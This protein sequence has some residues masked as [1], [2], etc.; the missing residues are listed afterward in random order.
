MVAA[1]PVDRPAHRVAQEP[2]LQ[3]LVLYPRVHSQ[4]GIE[5]SFR[6][7]ISDEFERPEEAASA[8]VAHVAMLAERATQLVFEALPRR[9]DLGE[10]ATLAQSLLHCQS[11]GTGGGMSE[12]GGAVLEEP[13][14]A[15]D[16]FVDRPRHDHR[17]DR[18]ISGAQPLGDRDDVGHDGFALEGPHRSAAAHAAHHFV[19]D[20]QDGVPHAR[21]VARHRW[22]AAERRARDRFGDERDHLVAAQALDL[23]LE[24][25]AQAVDIGGVGLAFAPIAVRIA[26]RNMGRADEQRRELLAPPEVAADGERAERIAVI[27]LPAA[28]DLRALRLALLDEVLPR[29]LERRFHRL[30][31]ARGEVDAVERLRRGCDQRIG[32]RFHR[33]VGEEGRVRIGQR[34]QLARDRLDHRAVGVA[35]AADCGAAGRIEVAPAF[36]VPLLRPGNRAMDCDGRRG[37]SEPPDYT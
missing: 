28:D 36:A 7:A 11:A 29:E 37:P 23:A 1:L 35:Q 25:R 18:L 34:F 24:L 3:R 6:F 32:Q 27:R 15:G 12:V 21:E 4:G 30:G 17:A 14:A 10:H 33:L 8:N 19:E 31:S 9:R 16:G 13:A 26:R 2:C 22:H 5:R 20:E